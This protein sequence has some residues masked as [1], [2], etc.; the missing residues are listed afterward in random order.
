MD[1]STDVGKIRFSGIKASLTSLLKDNL[2]IVKNSTSGA[3]LGIVHYGSTVSKTYYIN[4]FNSVEDATDVIINLDYLGGDSTELVNVFRD[5]KNIVQHETFRKNI[6]TWVIHF[7]L[8]PSLDCNYNNFAEACDITD[9]LKAKGI[10]IT[11]V[12]LI[13]DETIPNPTNAMGSP[14]YSLPADLHLVEN[15][16]KLMGNISIESAITDY[17]IR[18][19]NRNISSIWL[20]FIFV[21]DTSINMEKQ[22][23]LSSFGSMISFLSTGFSYNVLDDFYSRV[24][25]ITAGT[26]TTIMTMLSENKDLKDIISLLH[27][28]KYTNS[29][30]LDTNKALESV[31]DIIKS[32]KV[33]REDVPTVVVFLSANDNYDCKSSTPPEFCSLASRIK[34]RY[35][36]YIVNIDVAEPINPNFLSHSI[37]SPGMDIVNNNNLISKLVEISLTVNCYCPRGFAQFIGPNNETRTGECVF[38]QTIPAG[39]RSAQYACSTLKGTLVDTTTK[40]KFLWLKTYSENMPFW[41]GLNNLNGA[42]KFAWDNGKSLVDDLILQN[43]NVTSEEYLYCTLRHG[44]GSWE[45]TEC[46]FIVPSHPYFC[47]INACDTRTNCL[48]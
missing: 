12:N 46:S 31:E 40:Y 35:N 15:L 37:A 32:D 38:W 11:I 42:K 1:S 34:D 24:A 5:V 14:S 28:I 10:I 8:E 18:E 44:D 41:I 16:N 6:P 43:M 33:G 45:A 36:T 4:D 27:S 25:I 9:Q 30:T 20:D 29:E 26:D 47:Q 2:L 22:G 3:K 23:V 19:C 13:S 17:S 21:I 48:N 7:T 39:Y